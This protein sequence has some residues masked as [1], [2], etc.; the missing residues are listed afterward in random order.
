MTIKIENIPDA[1]RE[2][3]PRAMLSVDLL[4][5]IQDAVATL[6]VETFRTRLHFLP[7]NAAERA[8]AAV[9]DFFEL[10]ETRPV[11]DNSGGSGFNDSLWLYV[12]TRSLAQQPGAVAA[13]HA[14]LDDEL[15]RQASTAATAA[16]CCARPV[17][18]RPYSVSMSI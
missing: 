2:A 4:W 7:G 12:L 10:Y 18:T 17:R 1:P 8:S 11:R 14:A 15:G 9:F 13:V 3:P 16:G 6:V 5:R